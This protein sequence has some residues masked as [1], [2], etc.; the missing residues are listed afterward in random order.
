MY[1]GVFDMYPPFFI[2]IFVSYAL[3]FSIL[4][5]FACSLYY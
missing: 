3:N 1:T 4:A 5:T 2:I